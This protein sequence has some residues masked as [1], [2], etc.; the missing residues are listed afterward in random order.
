MCGI[1][2]AVAWRGSGP[3]YSSRD[4][5]ND[6][7]DQSL[8]SIKHRGPDGKGKWISNDL[9]VGKLPASNSQNY[10]AYSTTPALSHNRLAIVDLN[11]EAEQPFH[12]ADNNVHAVVNGELYG[13]EKI[14]EDLRAK[15]HT[16]RSKCDSE[17][18]V[19]LYKEHGISFLSHLRGEFSLCLYDSKTKIIIAACDRY[20]VKP[21]YY[22]IVEGK[23]LVWAYTPKLKQIC[24]LK[25]TQIASEAKAFIPFQWKPEWDIQSIKDAGWLCD[26]RTIFNGV[27]K[28]LPGHY[29]MV[30]SF[31]SIS[32]HKYWDLDFNDKVRYSLHCQEQTTDR[33]SA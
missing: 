26:R 30:N 28:I 15:G 18:A 14:M 12:D 31:S 16:F 11:P 21:L 7:L 32:Q 9:R 3:L 22:T 29:L 24:S 6:T 2:C 10:I 5:L 17:I 13:Y 25:T 33:S 8:D 19:A 27:Q 20:A 4:M 23:L 1:S